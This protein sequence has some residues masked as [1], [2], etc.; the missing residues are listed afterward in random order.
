MV[1]LRNCERLGLI[2]TK[3]NESNI[4]EKIE[5][6]LRLINENIDHDSPEDFSYV[7]LAYAPIMYIY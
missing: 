2:G 4:W 5:K 7:Y 1:T 6:I 3:I